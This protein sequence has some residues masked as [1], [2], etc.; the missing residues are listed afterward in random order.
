MNW[1]NAI[2]EVLLI[3]IGVSIALAANSWYEDRQKREEERA[4]LAQ[5]RQTLELDLVE[6]EG[7]QRAHL[8]QETG[9]IKLLE[10]MEG[11]DAYSPELD[12]L[13]SLRSK[14]IN[15]YEELAL[16]PAQGALN[17]RAFVVS[18]IGPYMDRNF[19]FEDS[20]TM[21]PIDYDS[22]RRDVYFRNLCITKLRRLQNFI[23]PNYQRT[24]KM[25]RELIAAVDIESE[26]WR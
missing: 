24:N 20:R 19:V 5:I 6:F 11:D 26:R 25:I 23:L 22:L 15:Y 2:G 14:I 21:V 10:H 3:V 9:I 8:E 13:G 4:I 17:D 12:F 1:R 16:R 7:H 18:R